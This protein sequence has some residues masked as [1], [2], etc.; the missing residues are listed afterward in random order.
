[1]SRASFRHL[2]G[3][4]SRIRRPAFSHS[5]CEWKGNPTAM[6]LCSPCVPVSLEPINPGG[7]TIFSMNL[8]ST[9]RVERR[10]TCQ[11]RRIS[12]WNV[13]SG[14]V[15]RMECG[16]CFLSRRDGVIGEC[17]NSSQIDGIAGRGSHRGIKGRFHAITDQ[18]FQ[19]MSPADPSSL[20]NY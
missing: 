13:R 8:G 7:S 18:L 9:F 3:R 19:L 6:L 4:T 16:W 15:S 5:S 2:S 1:M 12:G 14:V 17:E 10:N 11:V 20:L